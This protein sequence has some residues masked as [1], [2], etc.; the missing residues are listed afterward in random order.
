MGG[1][2]V[3]PHTPLIVPQTYF[4][5]F[6][7]ESIRLPDIKAADADD[8]FMHTASDELARGRKIHDSLVKSFG[9]DHELALKSFIQTYL[10]SVASVDDLLGKIMEIVDNS[11][12]KDNTIVV[13]TSDHGW[14]NGENGH[15]YKNTLWQESTRVPPIVRA[16][17]VSKASAECALPVSLVDLYP[18]LIDLCGLPSDTMKNAKGRPLDG[19]SLRPLLTAPTGSWKG[20]DEALTALYKWAKYY[21]PAKQSYSLRFKD[22][23]YIRYENGTEELYNTTSD[24]HE[25]TNLALNPEYRAKLED[26]R[27]KLLAR[28]P[29]SIPEPVQDADFWKADF[30]KR[31]PKADSNGDGTLSWPEFKAAKAQEK[32]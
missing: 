31:N 25:W 8:T 27:S 7:L 14:G 10:A 1:G 24:F 21:D 9:G 2:F 4:D 11:S 23:R 15:L 32:R 3:R 12:L 16:P 18:T 5:R 6:P 26:C 22:W 29:E 13:F 28:I 17:G 20:P 19:S 30:F